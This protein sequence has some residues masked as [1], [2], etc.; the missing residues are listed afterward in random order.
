M[1]DAYRRKVDVFVHDD[2]GRI[3]ASQTPRG[4]YQFPGGGIDP[5]ETPNQAAKREILEEVAWQIGRPRAIPGVRPSVVPWSD[6]LKEEYARKGRIFEGTKTYPRFAPAVQQD[7]SVLGADDDVM[8]AK[9][10]DIPTLV[11]ALTASSQDPSHDFQAYDVEKL[12]ALRGLAPVLGAKTEDDL[13]SREDAEGKAAAHSP[14][15]V[16]CASLPARQHQGV[17]SGESLQRQANH[18]D[19]V[20]SAHAASWEEVVPVRC[21]RR[22]DD[23]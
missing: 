22:E 7:E 1:N 3:L 8:D 4:S 23:G 14:S 17:R 21:R 20:V 11:A 9:F 5:G 12:K 13:N 15:E 18:H 2:T 19:S 16:P 6:K 10:V